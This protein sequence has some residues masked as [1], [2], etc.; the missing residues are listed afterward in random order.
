MIETCRLELMNK[1]GTVILNI[2]SD[3]LLSYKTSGSSAS[4]VDYFKLEGGRCNVVCNASTE[5]IDLLVDHNYPAGVDDFMAKS[6][7]KYFDIWGKVYVDEQAEFTGAISTQSLVYDNVKETISVVLDDYVNIFIKTKLTTLRLGYQYDTKSIE[8]WFEYLVDSMGLEITNDLY[9][10]NF[11]VEPAV[12]IDV[13]Y[14]LNE[15][16]A[17]GPGGYMFKPDY[18][19]GLGVEQERAAAAST[20]AFVVTEFEGNIWLCNY[21]LRTVCEGNNNGVLPDTLHWWDEQLVTFLVF[22]PE[23]AFVRGSTGRTIMSN[24]NWSGYVGSTNA[25]AAWCQNKVLTQHPTDMDYHSVFTHQDYPNYS[26]PDEGSTE[27]EYTFPNGFAHWELIEGT[28]YVLYEGENVVQDL[29]VEYGEWDSDEGLMKYDWSKTLAQVLYFSNHT[30]FCEGETI[31][32][33]PKYPSHSNTLHDI[34]QEEILSLSHKGIIFS[35]SNVEDRL[36][37]LDINEEIRAAFIVYIYD[38][39]ERLQ[40]ELAAVIT[41]DGRVI[42]IGDRFTIDSKNYVAIKVD[43]DKSKEQIKI[44]GILI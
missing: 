28:R 6:D 30:I 31:Y 36:S 12:G 42:R 8:D 26:L 21:V 13:E 19:D 34:P 38:I 39:Y 27:Y 11:T 25:V 23:G 15:Y 20:G 2:D 24:N 22:T 14:T 35:V 1:N 40:Q 32:I 41:D 5:L 3:T 9:F 17:W 4:S 16:P 29:R 7:F 44:G 18:N 33:K 37:Q 43:Y 10:K